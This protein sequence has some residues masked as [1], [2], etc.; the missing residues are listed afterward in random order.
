MSKQEELEALAAECDRAGALQ[1][2]ARLRAILSRAESGDR[3]N[4]L[5]HFKRICD[6]CGTVIAQCRCMDCNKT[7]V[8]SICDKCKAAAATPRTEPDALRELLEEARDLI[9]GEHEDC[10]D[11]DCESRQLAARIDAALTSTPVPAQE[12]YPL[13]QRIRDITHPREGPCPLCA[14]I[15]DAHKAG[16]PYEA[17]DAALAAYESERGK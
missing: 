13:P 9:R 16:C 2:A 7:V 10:R 4:D 14:H 12:S 15:F 3:H 8:H 5:G 6:K 17:I 1:I 11:Q